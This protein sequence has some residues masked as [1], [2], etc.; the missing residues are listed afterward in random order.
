M[1]KTF[2]E[3]TIYLHEIEGCKHGKMYFWGELRQILWIT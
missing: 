3:V 1:D 2:I